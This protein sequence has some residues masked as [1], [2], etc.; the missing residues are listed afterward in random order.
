MGFNFFH[1]FKW[2]LCN[3]GEICVGNFKPTC[4]L[5]KSGQVVKPK[6]STKA[7]KGHLMG[8]V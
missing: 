7:K 1:R 2:C 5:C 8:I 6:T 4:E 3:G